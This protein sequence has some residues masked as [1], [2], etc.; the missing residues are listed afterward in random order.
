MLNGGERCGKIAI[1]LAELIGIERRG[2][3]E[4]LPLARFKENNES[5]FF[6]GLAY[7]TRTKECS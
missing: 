6:G 4:A 7:K 5:T 1:R 3:G 2:N